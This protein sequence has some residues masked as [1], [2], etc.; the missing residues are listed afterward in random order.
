MRLPSCE[1]KE[2]KYKNDQ[3]EDKQECSGSRD[4]DPQQMLTTFTT[5]SFATI[6]ASLADKGA[7]ISPS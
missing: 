6:S 4:E 7:F 3:S 5:S 2:G 1:N